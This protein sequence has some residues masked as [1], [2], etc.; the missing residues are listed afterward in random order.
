M[1]NAIKKIDFSFNRLI[2]LFVAAIM[3]LLTYCYVHTESLYL[4]YPWF[5]AEEYYADT[6]IEFKMQVFSV[7]TV[8]MLL[9][10]ILS[11]ITIRS[12][13]RTK[14][15]KKFWL[16]LATIIFTVLSTIFA[17]NR[18][19]A[20]N[21]APEQTE[22]MLVVIGYALLP[23]FIYLNIKSD[24]DILAVVRAFLVGSAAASVIGIFQIFGIN[25]LS[26][27]FLTGILVSP[28]AR[29]LG[30]T[31][32]K[33]ASSVNST[34]GNSN[35]AGVYAAMMF[36]VCFAVILSDFKKSVRIFA[37]ADCILLLVFLIGTKSDASMVFLAFVVLVCLIFRFNVLKKYK[38]MLCA[39][40]IIIIL[41]GVITGITT[42]WSYLNSFKSALGLTRK[43]YD[44]T[45]IDTTGDS[46]KLKYKGNEL[47][48]YLEYL[49]VGFT[50]E[51]TENG[52]SL[53]TSVS[54]DYTGTITLLS[55]EELPIRFDFDSETNLLMGIAFPDYTV[56]FCLYTSTG[57]Y[58]LVAPSNY[59]VESFV[60]PNAL[61][62]Y[63]ALISNRGYI[64]GITMP[65][66]VNYM[67]LGAGPDNFPMAVYG[68]GIDYADRLNDG[69]WQVLFLTAHSYYF[70]TWICEGFVA[71]VLFV[72]FYIKY[73]VDSI[74][75]YF[76]KQK[77]SG[78]FYL[79]LGLMAGVLLFLMAGVSNSSMVSTGPV[80]YT[81]LGLG[82]VVNKRIAE[83]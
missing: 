15:L 41:A 83:E 77:K 31:L 76:M 69:N 81:I 42:K 16:I 52:E 61:T 67:L 39:A 29:E 27:D 66:L 23:L 60:R 10:I 30:Y 38:K 17:I 8:Y 36:L 54:S 53:T 24:K 58:L 72:A 80:F 55:G 40:G 12:D 51:V 79:G 13:E 22:P 48:I 71:L 50:L 14:I 6:A 56:A 57:D 75:L 25:L 4:E 11:F 3:P 70:Q 45:E 18:T 37:G 82:I 64:W 65:Q 68:S 34:F 73:F 33:E 49:V 47:N 63:G 44:L 62:G 19:A 26:L 32:S 21:G 2:I 74:K 20:L 7:I 5:Y 1:L 46:I 78:I 9:S 35:Y 59:Y 43:S 28:Y